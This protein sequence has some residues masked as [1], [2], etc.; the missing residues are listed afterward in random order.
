MKNFTYTIE[1]YGFDRKRAEM[2]NKYLQLSK[3][4]TL[5]MSFHREVDYR[6]HVLPMDNLGLFI[7]QNEAWNDIC[8]KAHI[9]PRPHI[10]LIVWSS[11]HLMTEFENHY[12]Y[13]KQT[14]QY[15][16]E[17]EDVVTKSRRQFYETLFRVPNLHVHSIYISDKMSEAKIEKQLTLVF[18]KFYKNIELYKEKPVALKHGRTFNILSSAESNPITGPLVAWIKTHTPFTPGHEI[19]KSTAFVVVFTE[20]LTRNWIDHRDVV[21]NA[22]SYQHEWGIPVLI[23]D[24]IKFGSEIEDHENFDRARKNTADLKKVLPEYMHLASNAFL[25]E[26]DLLVIQPIRQ[27]DCH[28]AEKLQ[29]IMHTFLQK[30]KKEAA[31]EPVKGGVSQQAFDSLVRR[32][33]ILEERLKEVEELKSRMVEMDKVEEMVNTLM[34]IKVMEILGKIDN[35]MMRRIMSQENQPDDTTPQEP[36]SSATTSDASQFDGDVF[37]KHNVVNLRLVK[38]ESGWDPEALQRAIINLPGMPLSEFVQTYVEYFVTKDGK[39]FGMDRVMPVYKAHKL[40]TVADVMRDPGESNLPLKKKL[41]VVQIVLEILAEKF[42]IF[43]DWY[44]YKK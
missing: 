36:E 17:D 9:D 43:V 22:L 23:L 41:R 8:S 16:I 11:E 37:K 10:V 1:S 29:Y 28:N 32:V 20:S 31:P 42:G 15:Q 21:T 4:H 13:F 40:H 19:N 3:N 18:D 38:P 27:T 14:R 33:E 6:V 44:Q 34:N 39:A 2:I 12:D 7:S 35:S 5:A 26:N 30:V 25:S 24:V